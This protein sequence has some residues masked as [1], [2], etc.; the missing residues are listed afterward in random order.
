[1]ICSQLAVV[2]SIAGDGRVF[3]GLNCSVCRPGLAAG[4]RFPGEDAVELACPP[5]PLR[6]F[7]CSGAQLSSS[8]CCWCLEFVSEGFGLSETRAKRPSAGCLLHGTPPAVSV[9][10]YWS[11][12][13]ARGRVVFARDGFGSCYVQYFKLILSCSPFVF[14]RVL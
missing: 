14:P 9:R 11:Y 13:Q 1:M 10:G 3:S 7:Y 4:K 6:V 5:T 8:T 2:C 12:E